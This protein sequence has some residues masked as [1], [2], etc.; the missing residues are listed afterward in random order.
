MDIE[1]AARLIAQSRSYIDSVEIQQKRY[2]RADFI[3]A[4]QSAC[5]S[6]YGPNEWDTYGGR[7]LLSLW[8][9]QPQPP[10][11]VHVRDRGI[12]TSIVRVEVALDLI[13]ASYADARMLQA[14]FVRHLF[15]SVRPGENVTWKETTAYFAY[16]SALGAGTSVAIYADKESKAVPGA[17]CCHIEWRISGSKALADAS[18]RTPSQ[19]LSLDHT[20]FW[21]RALRLVETPVPEQIGALWL[22]GFTS[23]RSKLPRQFPFRSRSESLRRV[24]SVFLRPHSGEDGEV[25]SNNDL[26]VYLYQRRKAFTGQSIASLFRPAPN[27]WL[28]PPAENA[29]WG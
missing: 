6:T 10:A 23:S 24:P 29:L 9:H 25:T 19:L 11:L 8:L 14:F 5:K 21:R 16:N 20:A 18:L 12:T 27:E 15:P 22:R 7:I 4:V 28:L 13:T 1:S 3:K 26:A 17:P 2:F